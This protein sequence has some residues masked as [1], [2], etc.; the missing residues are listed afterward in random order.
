MSSVNTIS[1][2][3]LARLIGT[4]KCPV[5]IDV[6]AP[7]D[8]EADPRLIPGSIR[9]SHADVADWAHEFSGR[10]AIVVCRKGL[11]LS[12]G[13]AA[14]LRHTGAAAD[15]LEGGIEAW[16]TAGLPLIPAGRLPTRTQQMT[17]SAGICAARRA[18]AT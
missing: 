8:F 12:Q 10:S 1:A 9:C 16:A 11:K 15:S 4:P 13:V 6:C 2:D 17:R 14:W 7:E 5:L 3:K 18:P